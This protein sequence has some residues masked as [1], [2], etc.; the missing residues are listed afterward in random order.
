MGGLYLYNKYTVSAAVREVK[1]ES[2]KG[3]CIYAVSSED[4]FL[5]TPLFTF[6]ELLLKSILKVI[7][8]TAPR[9]C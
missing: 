8:D 6:N 5:F 4:I 3:C 9:G 7:I 2:P 1:A